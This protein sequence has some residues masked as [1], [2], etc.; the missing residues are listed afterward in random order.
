[1]SLDKGNFLKMICQEWMSV[2]RTVWEYHEKLLPH[3]Y[4]VFIKYWQEYM[5]DM[6]ADR[7]WP[8]HP[9]E[10]G[11]LEIE[12]G[13]LEDVLKL[14]SRVATDQSEEIKR[15]NSS[16]VGSTL[17]QRGEAI[18]QLCQPYSVKLK[19]KFHHILKVS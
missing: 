9:N 12:R 17:F 10:I 13:R 6:I 16:I 1:M 5:Y 3:H 11:E 7:P 14:Y 19:V 2:S 15:L 8:L 18:L 4:E